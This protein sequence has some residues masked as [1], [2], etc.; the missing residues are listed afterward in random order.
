LNDSTKKETSKAN[1]SE[2]Q[3]MKEDDDERQAT[4]R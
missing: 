2:P 4:Q 3:H 1:E